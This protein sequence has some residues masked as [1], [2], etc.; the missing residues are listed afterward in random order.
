MTLSGTHA[1]VKRNGSLRNNSRGLCSEVLCT[2]VSAGASC[3]QRDPAWQCGLKAGHCAGTRSGALQTHAEG[4]ILPL[5]VKGRSF[6]L[7]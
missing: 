7:L 4:L 3:S 6:R 2:A 1:P 5:I